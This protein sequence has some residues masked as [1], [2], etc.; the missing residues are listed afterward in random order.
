MD[1]STV[2]RMC[3]RYDKIAEL[4]LILASQLSEQYP[5]VIVLMKRNPGR[6]NHGCI[7]HPSTRYPDRYQVSTFDNDGFA[8]DYSESSYRAAITQALL[9]GFRTVDME[10]LDTLCLTPR[11]MCGVLWSMQSEEHKWNSHPSDFLPKE[12]Q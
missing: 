1:T 2:N 3:T 11:F 4:R 5:S 9:E 12:S 6:P 7:I 10:I 8:Y